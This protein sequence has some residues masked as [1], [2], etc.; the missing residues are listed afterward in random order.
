[1]RLSGVLL[2]GVYCIIVYIYLHKAGEQDSLLYT[3]TIKWLFKIQ[4]DPINFFFSFV[5]YT[6]IFPPISPKLWGLI[7]Q[8]E[9]WNFFVLNVSQIREGFGEHGCQR[10]KSAE[11]CT[12]L[13]HNNIQQAFFFLKPIINL[14]ILY[15][16]YIIYAL[17]LY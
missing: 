10:K 9:L 13:H 7:E 12:R 15:C 16:V 3:L 11:N 14:H 5:H 2:T 6:F 17:L 8:M 1:M 4:G